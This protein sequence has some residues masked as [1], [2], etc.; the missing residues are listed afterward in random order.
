MNKQI[1]LEE[2]NEIYTHLWDD[3]G[4]EDSLNDAARE[5]SGELFPTLKAKALEKAKEIA[6]ENKVV[7]VDDIVDNIMLEIVVGAIQQ[8]ANYTVYLKRMN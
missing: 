4:F 7:D 3:E 2:A 8:L 5:V 6:Y 1:N